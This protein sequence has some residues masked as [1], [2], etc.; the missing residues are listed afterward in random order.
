MAERACR[1][2]ASIL[3]RV[4]LLLGLLEGGGS[5]QVGPPEGEPD[6][7]LE[8]GQ[9]LGPWNLEQLINPGLPPGAPANDDL[10]DWGESAHGVVLPPREAGEKSLVLMVCRRKDGPECN[11]NGGDVSSKAFLLD[12]DDPMALETMVV[13]GLS[14]SIDLG[15]RDPFCG[16]HVLT[17]AGD[18]FWA[19]GTDVPSDDR[20]RCDWRHDL[21]RLGHLAND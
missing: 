7:P 19:S 20:I 8:F 9:W 6:D 15:A 4:G 17:A 11:G 21:R 18:V 2:E 14:G 16:G 13:N 5:A 1:L 12:P 10:R 3:V